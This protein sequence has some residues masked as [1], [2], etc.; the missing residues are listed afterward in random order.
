MVLPLHS[1]LLLLPCPLQTS[2]L[3]SSSGRLNILFILIVVVITF[4]LDRRFELIDI[5]KKLE[6]DRTVGCGK[7]SLSTVIE[8]TNQRFVLWSLI[9]ATLRLLTEGTAKSILISV[10]GLE[11]SLRSNV[12]FVK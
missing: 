6:E 4:A 2:T 1:S 12:C 5:Y 11:F 9:R 3:Y 7:K 10:S 8:T